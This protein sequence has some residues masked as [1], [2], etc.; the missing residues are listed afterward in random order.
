MYHPTTRRRS[1]SQGTP[2]YHKG[3]L[4]YHK[5][6]LQMTPEEGITWIDGLRV[7]L[8]RKKQRERAYLSRRAARG[9]HTPTDDA[10]EED[11]A[12]ETELIDLL[13]EIAQELA[14]ETEPYGNL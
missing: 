10:Y 7:R 11:Q 5:S 6:L 3:T 1:P 2:I 13:N 14:K 12:L 4:T 9:T 8:S